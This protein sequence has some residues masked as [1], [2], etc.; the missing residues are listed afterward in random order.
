MKRKIVFVGHPKVH[1]ALQQIDSNWDLQIPLDTLETFENEVSEDDS[2]ISSETSV[3]IFLST[4]YSRNKEK[5]A[6]LI[7]QSS[8]Y[9]VSC[10]LVYP[11]DVSLKTEIELTVK[12]HQANYGTPNVPFYFIDYNNPTEIYSAIENFISS[13]LIDSDIKEAVKMGNSDYDTPIDSYIQEIDDELFDKDDELFIPEPAA[14]AK[15]KV[16]SVTSSKGGSGKS[17][18]AVGLG[19]YIAKASNDAALKG[20]TDKS[21][22]VCIVDLDVRDGQLGFL[23]GVTKPTIIDILT[24]GEPTIENIQ[25]GIYHSEKL[26]VDFI[27]AAKRPRNAQG[28]SS[29]FYAQLIQNL[30]ILYDIV[31]LD[32]SV[33][34]LDP[35]LEQVAYPISDVI[36]FVTNMVN[37]SIFGMS[38]WILEETESAELGDKAIS[39]DKI[40]IVVN[41]AMPNINMSEDKIRKASKGLPI[42]ALIPSAPSLVAY[43]ANTYELGRILNFEPINRAFKDIAESIIDEPLGDVP[44]IP[45]K[46]K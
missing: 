13:P 27:F 43:A 32:T 37:Q 11:N 18:V 9:S 41:Q 23:N 15:G 2:R 21:L 44:F 12:K 36:L 17:T 4:L 38:R 10:V 20:L 14:N 6:E 42:L 16:F 28:I 5:F 35:L 8:P 31:I 19:A 30:R 33:N 24:R 46:D 25:D 3:V 22:K 26:N 7:A 40:G 39:K 29:N 1:E 34:Y 45:I